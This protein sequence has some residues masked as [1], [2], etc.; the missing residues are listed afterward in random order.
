[1]KKREREKVSLP[2]GRVPPRWNRPIGLLLCCLGRSIWV[3]V[4]VCSGSFTEFRHEGRIFAI[5]LRCSLCTTW[6][7]S[8]TSKPRFVS[9]SNTIPCH[10]SHISTVPAHHICSE[11]PLLWTI[12]FPMTELSAILTRLILIVSQSSVEH[13]ELSKLVSLVVVLLIR[14]RGGSSDDF[15][16]EPCTSIDFVLRVGSDVAVQLIV[17]IC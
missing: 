15:V 6:L 4:N 5:K 12:V 17:L 2:I 1:M 10:V 9:M 3:L 16:D 13:G 11:I 7:S 14:G 8:S